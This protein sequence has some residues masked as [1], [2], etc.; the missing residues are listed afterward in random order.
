MFLNERNT[1]MSFN[2]LINDYFKSNYNKRL[3]SSNLDISDA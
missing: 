2:Y 1:E 3:A